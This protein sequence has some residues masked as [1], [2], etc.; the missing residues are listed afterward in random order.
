MALSPRQELLLECQR[1]E[2]LLRRVK[3]RANDFALSKG[4]VQEIAA[5]VRGVNA[6]LRKAGGQ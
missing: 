2:E 6:S 1:A 4:D 5:V 3:G